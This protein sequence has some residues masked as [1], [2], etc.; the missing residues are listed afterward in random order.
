[1]IPAPPYPLYLWYIISLFLS[2]IYN[3]IIKRTKKTFTYYT[4]NE[5]TNGKVYCDK[6]AGRSGE[7]ATIYAIADSGYKVE[8]VKVNGK[9]ISVDAYGNY[10]FTLAAGTNVVEVT[11]VAI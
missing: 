1:M 5:V 9:E 7:S 2:C 3:D 4:L 6:L 10:T 11:F 8:S